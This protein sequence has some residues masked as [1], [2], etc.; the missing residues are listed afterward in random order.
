VDTPEAWLDSDDRWKNMLSSHF[1]RKNV[2]CIVVDEAH[3]VSWGVASPSDGAVFRNAFSRIG[4]MRSFVS[5]K[6]PVLALSA[7][8]D[9]DYREIINI[10]CSL[11]PLLN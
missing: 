10:C 1:F 3:K 9:K 5:E 11:S 4:D 8:V 7:T 2:K 6:V